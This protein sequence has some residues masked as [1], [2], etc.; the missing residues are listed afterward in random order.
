M[1]EISGLTGKW[2][3]AGAPHK[4]WTCID[5]ADL[6]GIPRHLSDVRDAGNPLRPPYAT[7]ALGCGCVCA[8]HMEENHEGARQ[9]ERA[10][11]NAS[12]RR[13]RWLTRDRRISRNGNPFLNADGYNVVVYRLVAGGAFGSATG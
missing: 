7:D 10:L 4:G 9:R 11:R 2:S 5:I 3:K 8:G 12:A 1:S 6:G 13:R